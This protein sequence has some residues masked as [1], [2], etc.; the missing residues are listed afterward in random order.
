MVA[1][2]SII[3]VAALLLRIGV[4]LAF[5]NI[6]YADEIFQTIEQGHRL[7][8]GYGIIPW[9]FRIGTRSWIVPGLLG[10]LLSIGNGV[11]LSRPETLN[12]LIVACLSLLSLSVVVVGF[13]WARR[14]ENIFAGLITAAVCAVWFELVYFAPKSLSEVIAAHVLV[15]AL[16]MA[17]PGQPTAD[18]RRLLAAGILLGVIVTIRVHLA[19]ALLVA[20]IYVCR[21]DIKGRWAPLLLGGS[22]TVIMAGMLDAL[23]W[24]YPFQS[25]FLN[26]WINLVE[27]R[28][29][30]WGVMPWY[31]FAK[32]WVALWGG[33]IVP[34]AALA[35]LATRKHLVLGLTAA[36]IIATHMLFGH[37]E[38]RFVFPAVPLI[39]IL[40]GLGTA[41]VFDHYRKSLK[42]SKLV[43]A[44]LVGVILAWTV[45]SAILAIGEKFR[46]QWFQLGSGIRA[47]HFLHDE[48]ELC[49]LGL[50]G[51]GW[52]HIG[53]YAHL[54]RRV[55]IV[56]TYERELVDSYPAYNYALVHRAALPDDWPYRE[57]RCWHREEVCI[58]RRDG[59]CAAQ[60][61]MDVNQVLIRRG[62]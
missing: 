61:E 53:G 39:V 6:H 59:S 9:E 57:V 32:E 13:L 50:V 37:K 30:Q 62:E 17:C 25:F 52:H 24:R 18:R 58:Y 3:L 42:E 29:L 7:A 34:I 35:M 36:T 60:P 41:E 16:Y 5:P 54:H 33:A 11:G 44:S 19:P 12:G 31:F 46:G 14:S 51:V 22:T 26:L 28:S 49:A 47:L 27:H 45:T 40:I 1:S 21:Y 43:W 8:F 10:G 38:Y 20:A 2:I 4:A 15:I 56:P 55:P 23:T 48:P